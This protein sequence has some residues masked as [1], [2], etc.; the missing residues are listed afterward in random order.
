ME[1]NPFY[2]TNHIPN[3]YFCDREAETEKLM[4]AIWNQEHVVLSAQRR[5]GKTGLI[6]HCFDS[7]YVSTSFY[8]ISIDI[9]HTS[10]LRE[11]VQEL[12]N[13]VYRKVAS[14]SQ[15]LM[16]AFSQAI[17]SLSASFGYDP[18]SATPTF[19]ITLGDIE[20][21]SYTLDEIFHYL[22]SAD[23]PCLIAIDEFQQILRYPDNK[24]EELL[25]G[26]IQKLVNTHLI[27]AG[28]ERRLMAEMFN[29]EKRP[30]Y[31][32]ATSI[33]LGPINLEKYIAFADKQFAKT[34]KLISSDGISYIYLKFEGITSHIH[35]VLHDAYAITLPGQTCSYQD[36]IEIS[37]VYLQECSSRIKELLGSVS[38]QQKEL[39]YVIC[40]EKKVSGITSSTF[41]KKHNLKSASS[42]QAA[43]KALINNGLISKAGNQYSISDP[44]MRIWI[45]QNFKRI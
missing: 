19:C 6:N 11:F 21:P 32:S 40:E 15:R 44:L 12:G 45:E 34:R 29:S 28:S 22:E 17:R 7:K 25:R 39:F 38:E 14:K 4:K 16:K 5:I 31:Q 3:E 26:K 8:T 18:V 1:I 41:V 30:F 42:V 10:S 24:V 13:A 43:V 2:L 37:D 23:K 9:L 36:L 20:E 27:F 35:R 33:E